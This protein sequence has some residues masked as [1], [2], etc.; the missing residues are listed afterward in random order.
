MSFHR[1]RGRAARTRFARLLTER[2]EERS[3][4]A[5]VGYQVHLLPPDGNLAGT[6]LTSVSVGQSYDLV[7]SVRDLRENPGPNAGVFAGYVDVG[8]DSAKTRVQVGEV[9][10]IRIGPFTAENPAGSASG[11]FTLIS[12]GHT[13]APITFNS[14]VNALAAAAE[15]AIGALNGVGL[16]NVTVRPDIINGSNEIVLQ[17][18]FLNKFYDQNVANLIVAS[19]NLSG[20]SSPK[21][22]LTYNGDLGSDEGAAFAFTE[23][24]RSR[25]GTPA[26]VNGVS[27]GN[28]PNLLDDV[29]AFAGFTPT[30]TG[31]KELVRARMVATAAGSVTFTAD[32]ASRLLPAHN[33]LL[34][35]PISPVATAEIDLGTPKTLTI[36]SAPF[37][38]V[39]DF[40]GTVTNTY[41]PVTIDVL[42]N[43]ITAPGGGSTSIVSVSQPPV[44]STAISGNQIHY[45]PAAGFTGTETF[46]YVARGEPGTATSTGTVTVTVVQPSVP[47]FRY[48]VRLVPPDGRL[49]TRDPQNAKALVNMADLAALHVGDEYDMVITVQPTSMTP[50][51]VYGG[52]TD[53]TYDPTK[54]Q[55]KAPEV[56][57]L[58]I[59]PFSASNTS[60]SA[61]GTFQLDFGGQ[62][63]APITYTSNFNTLAS[64]IQT[65][66]AA[67]PGV[68][69]GQ[70][71]VSNSGSTANSGLKFKIVFGG[72]YTGTN[73]A[74]LTIAA[75]NLTGP[76]TP[77]L[78]VTYD[79]DLQG[80]ALSASSVREAFRPV[81]RPSIVDVNDTTVF[82]DQGYSAGFVSGRI[83][84]VGGFTLLDST[85]ALTSAEEEA[86]YMIAPPRELVR[87]RFR[88]TAAGTV[89][90]AADL[91]QIQS[92][93]H[94]SL[95]FGLRGNLTAEMISAGTPKTL[96]ISAVQ[97]YAAAAD[98]ATVREDASGVTIDVLAND[99]LPSSSTSK[100]I[101][102][103]TQPGSGT[104]TQVGQSLRYVPVANFAGTVTFTYI[105]KGEGMT[106]AGLFG[107]ATV[108]VRVDPVNDPPTL[109]AIADSAALLEDAA[110]QTISL[111]GIA[112]GGG[113]SQ[114]LSVTAES[115]N[116][117][118]T[119]PISINYQSPSS[120]GQ[121]S[122][123]PVANASGSAT[124][125]VSVKDH[126]GTAD[127]GI[128]A[129]SRTFSVVVTPVNDAPTFT[130]SP[131]QE[132]TDESGPQS[133]LNWAT[134]ISA[135]PGEPDQTVEFT[136]VP[137]NTDLFSVPPRI[138]ASGTLTYTPALNAAGTTI[139]SVHLT[140]SGPTDNGGA[141]QS[142]IRTFS[143]RIDKLH[144]MHNAVL[145]L[146]VTGDLAITA[147][148]ALQCINNINAFGSRLV[149]T[150]FSEG[151]GILDVNG[152]NSSSADPGFLDVNGD[153][154]ISAQ[155]PLAIINYI[156]AFGSGIPKASDGEGEAAAS[157]FSTLLALLATD[158]ADATR[159]RR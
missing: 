41:I 113:E 15:L 25:L 100:Q 21:V 111:A 89:T 45:I 121:L 135:G 33:T 122:F 22:S 151:E 61:S 78:D 150:L 138:D 152:D 80:G 96:T 20:P 98:D 32:V 24:F 10:R 146:D 137:D 59:G 8:Y 70:I 83:D 142:V 49:Y 157:D 16:G 69:P 42:D 103:F 117:A 119:G 65:A 128:D 149:A 123:Q 141:R 43:D 39:A 94:D 116:P 68:G 99:T 74:N 97:P 36:A 91:S 133:V 130:P 93:A 127:G 73:V 51:G 76:T 19:Q 5:Q 84:D 85:S 44:G 30:G 57:F 37:V 129:I 144:P 26:F 154:L 46:T 145:P 66:M 120:A 102:S 38:A 115:S 52:Y 82:F 1:I 109:D 108:T 34:F 105:A 126:G 40:Y 92:P 63:S 147:N 81:G 23:S 110:Q 159:K 90:L 67:L 58:T 50:L 14:D 60:S 27:A 106:N 95:V 29:G 7:V 124:I 13:T 17:V 64:R 156:N 132:A 158:T 55:V 47:L 3:L 79:G 62:I 2:L 28:Q 139:V 12:N 72:Q 134:G 4:L 118:L 53:V 35:D 6:E 114:T 11:S 136:A 9:Q 107:T 87:A 18:R 54:T 101:V 153:G 131:N 88:A 77:V 112:A 48:Q 86:G 140:D 104:V 31:L 143:I 125:V 56:Q 71:T 148:D 75:N 155:D